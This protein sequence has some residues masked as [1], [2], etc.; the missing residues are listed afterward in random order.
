MG[1][2]EEIET[3][4]ERVKRRD[5]WLNLYGY[6]RGD[7]E[8]DRQLLNDWYKIQAAKKEEGRWKSGR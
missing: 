5:K 3:T 2:D 8:I 7:M 4:E 6:G 1:W